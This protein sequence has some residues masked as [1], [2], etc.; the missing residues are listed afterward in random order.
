M[1]ISFTLKKYFFIINYVIV[2]SVN[3]ENTHYVTNFSLIFCILSDMT[4]YQ[5]SLKKIWI[6]FQDLWFFTWLHQKEMYFQTNYFIVNKPQ[7]ISIVLNLSNV[8][9]AQKNIEKSNQKYIQG[10]KKEQ[11]KFVY[12]Q[13]YYSFVCLF[14]KKKISYFYLG[15]M[16]FRL[17]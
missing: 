8:K 17:R 1:I 15:K 2:S 10:Q 5:C 16:K 9:T 14:L 3:F 11:I 6:R 13:V 7:S 12:S 4:M